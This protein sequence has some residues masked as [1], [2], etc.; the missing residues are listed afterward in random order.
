MFAMPCLS[1]NGAIAGRSK[2]LLFILVF[3]RLAWQ[4]YNGTFWFRD[5]FI[6]FAVVVIFCVWLDSYL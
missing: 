4:I 5:Y 1:Y 3:S 6:Y 2:I